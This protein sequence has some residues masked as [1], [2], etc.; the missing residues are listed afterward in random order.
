MKIPLNFKVAVFSIVN[1]W[2]CS[3]ANAD[4]YTL[5]NPNASIEANEIYNWLSHLPRRNDN[6]LL[7]GAFGGYSG[8]TDHNAFTMDEANDIQTQTGNFPGIYSCDY[9]RGWDSTTSGNEAD[10]IDYNCNSG[11]ITYWQSGGLIQI[12]NHLP[13]PVFAGNSSYDNSGNVVGG[14]KKQISNQQF[15]KI[16]QNGTPE[17]TRWLAIMDEV[18]NGLL[19]LQTAGV[20]VIYR[21]LHEMN[22]EWFW[23]GATGYNTNDTSRHT[24][25]KLL[26]RDMYNYFTSV[27]HLNNLIWVYSPDSG[28]SY[29]NSFYPGSAYVDI[30]GLDMYKH[31]PEALNIAHYNEMLLLNKPFA[32]AETGPKPGANNYFN[33]LFDYKKLIDNIKSK[34]PDTVYFIPWNSGWSPLNNLNISDTFNDSGV[35]NRDDIRNGTQLTNIIEETTMVYDFKPIPD[36][37]ADW[38]TNSSLVLGYW[39]VSEWSGD[40]KHSFKANINLQSNSTFNIFSDKQFNFSGKNILSAKVKLAHWGNVG[41]G[42]AVKF[43]VKTGST[44][45]WFDGGVNTFSNSQ[46]RTL[47][48]DLNNVTNKNDIRE[49]GIEIA[50]PS[51][52]SGQTAIYI[53]SII[54]QKN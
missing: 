36:R 26:Y 7:S 10:L 54:V 11:L 41:Q 9:A 25:Y 21:P 49:L 50:T 32:I 30:V 35:A 52:S 5:S 3:A 29:K 1:L 27:K 2:A 22:G 16:L 47:S 28:R 4:T 14:L 23:W 39:S 31:D 44:Y 48:I 51:N 40:D 8:I 15:V 53:D 38:H 20:T 19:E 45:Q 43:Y 13:N 46:Q 24:L 6:K 18:A 33:G 34:Y 37:M 42:I 12:S 17:R